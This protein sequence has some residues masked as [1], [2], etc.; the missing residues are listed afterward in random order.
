MGYIDGKT[1]SDLLIEE[2]DIEEDF[3]RILVLKVR[4]ISADIIMGGWGSLSTKV[5]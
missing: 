5:A 1:D 3:E 2:D 4:L